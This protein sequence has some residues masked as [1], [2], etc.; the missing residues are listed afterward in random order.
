MEQLKIFNDSNFGDIRVLNIDSEPWFVAKDICAAL[1][2]KNPRSAVTQHVDESEKG[3]AR[4]DTL[5][6]MQ[7]MVTINESGLYGLVFGSELKSAKEFKKWVTKEVL[8]TIRKNGMYATN[9]LLDNPDFLIEVATRLKEEREIRK[10]LEIKAEQDKPKID[11]FDA[12]A[13]SKTAIAIGDVA[14]VLAVK[15]VGRN[16]LFE[17]LRNKG[18]LMQNNQPY[19]RYVDNGYFRVVEQKYTKPDGETVINFK[20]LV[21]Q[22]GVAYI[23]KLIA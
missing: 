13:D 3:V 21:Y 11:F 19:Q 15:G 20:T 4:M 22:K 1:G 16:N 6:G 23:R 2:Y 9:E 18:V 12:V 14:K 7:E 10:A 8:P 17:L 5:G